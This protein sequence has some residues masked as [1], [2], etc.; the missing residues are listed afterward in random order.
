MVDGCEIRPLADK[1]VGE[2]LPQILA[3]LD[4][5]RG[6]CRAILY[7]ED[8]SSRLIYSIA[9]NFTSED[10]VRSPYLLTM[11]MVVRPSV[12]HMFASL[13]S[14]SLPLCWQPIRIIIETLTYSLLAEIQNEKAY[15]IERIEKVI[16]DAKRQ[17]LRIIHLLKEELPNHLP[18]FPSETVHKM[19]ELW[20][21]ASNDFLHFIGYFS[22]L[23]YWSNE[24]EDNPPPSFLVGA[25]VPYDQSD[26]KEL[27][28]LANAIDH[29]RTVLAEIYDYYINHL[30][31][32]NKPNS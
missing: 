21:Q 9:R 23:R 8:E 7:I 13:I 6:I 32:K 27:E 20:S 4:N 18:N 31:L 5:T 15:A 2:Y 1:V 29:L 3:S 30:S 19:V 10:I 16:E 25:F 22:K 14:G 17:Q 12:D 11:A 26:S 24:P 28:K